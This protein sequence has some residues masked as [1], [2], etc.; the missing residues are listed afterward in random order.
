MLL[1]KGHLFR[2]RL[3][4]KPAA[5]NNGPGCITEDI[6]EAITGANIAATAVSVITG[7]IDAKKRRSA[8]K[9]LRRY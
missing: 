2:R 5:R 9:R 3:T 4:P 1:G 6:V 7:D 8:R